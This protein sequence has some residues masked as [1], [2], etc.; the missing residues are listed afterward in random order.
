M[1]RLFVFVATAAVGS[2]T[3]AAEGLRT[4]PDSGQGMALNG[5]RLVIQD[6]AA[7]TSKNPAS[8]TKI[9]QSTL[10]VTYQPWH[11]KTDFTGSMG[12][13]ESMLDP[14]KH[15]GSLYFATP[16]NDTMTF[17]LG[18]T[19]P[20]GISIDWEKEGVFRYFGAHEAIL[21]TMALNP[22]LGLKIND[23]LSVGFGLDIFRSSLKFEQKFPWALVAGAPVPDGDMTFEGDGWGLGAY[24]GVNF[25]VGERHHFAFVGRLPVSVDYDGDFEITNI[26]APGA[27]APMSPFDSEIEHPGSLGLG[28][29][30][31]V[32]D[33][34]RIGVD[35][36]Y[37][38]NSS[39][40]DI[41]VGVGVNQAL[42]QKTT[43]PL[44]W[45]DSYSIGIAGEYQW[46]E[47]IVLRAGYQYSDSPMNNQ[48][49]NPSIPANDRHIISV[50]FGY[51]WGEDSQNSLDFAYS[52]I[53]MEDSN[54][55]G[56]IIPAFNG[57]YDYDWDILTL[58]YTRRF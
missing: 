26:P 47:Q 36:E 38:F 33:R 14:W 52:L 58:S 7:V 40:D 32:S 42:L 51:T 8:L 44:G 4:L 16:V 35:F 37:I 2:F 31:D 46:T 17:G 5:G 24:F 11:G 10:E 41:P 18:V 15:L 56:N 53:H 54:V 29:G 23:K 20:F 45:D 34:F 48:F 57:K 19:A 9:S 22:A 6:D 43:T 12:Q 55:S 1:K 3:Y 50:G 25:D 13:T 21:Q 27:A 49:F 28:Y 39:H 30:Y